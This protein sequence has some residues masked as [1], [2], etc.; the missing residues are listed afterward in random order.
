MEFQTN[1][2]VFEIFL[3]L[4]K[5]IFS[6]SAVTCKIMYRVRLRGA[7]LKTVPPFLHIRPLCLSLP[8]TSILFLFVEL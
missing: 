4:K 3:T 2:K 7:F 5:K 8:P 1:S 6:L